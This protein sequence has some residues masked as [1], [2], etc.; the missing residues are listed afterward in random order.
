M[1]AFGSLPLG[2]STSSSPVILNATRESSSNPEDESVDDP[3]DGSVL[4]EIF[5]ILSG[6]SKHQD[7]PPLPESDRIVFTYGK[8]LCRMLDS[9]SNL[10]IEIVS[11]NPHGADLASLIRTYQ[12]I[13]YR[14]KRLI[15]LLIVFIK[16]ANLHETFRIPELCIMVIFFLQ[17]LSPPLLPN[18]HEIVREYQ[19]RISTNSMSK[20]I[21]KGEDLSYLNDLSV[22]PKF[23]VSKNRFSL[24]ELWLKLLRFYVCEFHHSEYLISVVSSEPVRKSARK[25]R[26]QAIF[27]EDPFCPGVSLMNDMNVH[28]DKFF[29]DQLLAAYVYFGIPRLKGSSR[30]FFTEMR[31]ES[32]KFLKKAFSL[33]SDDNQKFA[34]VPVPSAERKSRLDMIASD[35]SKTCSD[36]SLANIALEVLQRAISEICPPKCTLDIKL[37]FG[38]SPCNP[39]PSYAID[40]HLSAFQVTELARACCQNL[41]T[42]AQTDLLEGASKIQL[43]VL[44]RDVLRKTLDTM[45]LISPTMEKKEDVDMPPLPKIAETMNSSN[46]A[47]LANDENNTELGLKGG[48]EMGEDV[49]EQG[50]VIEEM[51]LSDKQENSSNAWEK[52]ISIVD[53]YSYIVFDS[54]KPEFYNSVKVQKLSPD[55][56]AFPFSVDSYLGPI[57]MGSSIIFHTEKPPLACSHCDKRGHISSECPAV[58]LEYWH[59]LESNVPEAKDISHLNEL[60]TCF[61]QLSEYHKLSQE[62][63]ARHQGVVKRLTDLFRLRF[64]DI[65]LELFGSCAN[66]FET[67]NSDVDICVV[68][69]PGSPFLTCLVSGTQK[70]R[71]ELLKTFRKLLFK[72]YND[73]SISNVRPVY[74]AKVPIIK[75]LVD[76]DIEVDL[77]FSNHLAI[78]N[79]KM[80]RL[81]NE[82]EPRLR[83]LN[84]VLKVVLRSCNIPKSCDGG[85][86]SYAYAIM[87][88]H[89]LQRKGYLPCLQ[90]VYESKQRPEFIVNGWNA[91]YQEDK[92]IVKKHWK[93]PTDNINIAELWLGFLRYFLFEFDR[94]AYEVTIDSKE[95]ARR[96]NST[97]SFVIR[98]PFDLSHNMTQFVHDRLIIQIFTTFYDVL[99]HH[100]TFLQNDMNIEE[101]KISLFSSSKLLPNSDSMMQR[102]EKKHKDKAAKPA[103]PSK[104]APVLSTPTA[105]AANVSR[106]VLNGPVRTPVLNHIRGG[107]FYDRLSIGVDRFGNRIVTLP[108]TNRPTPTAFHTQPP[109]SAPQN[110]INSD[111]VGAAPRGRGGRGRGGV[112][113]GEIHSGRGILSHHARTRRNGG[114]IPTFTRSGYGA[115]TSHIPSSRT[116]LS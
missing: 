45:T 86:S 20:V 54:E 24:A 91:W 30:P 12:A 66:G 113:N 84:T 97:N 35:I 70:E 114:R 8:V 77:S 109:Y 100:S 23:F 41:W 7:Q 69:P 111:L 33:G 55:D 40:V 51:V 44:A 36:R 85:I 99:R 72:R 105:A 115:R 75:F 107:G 90:E 98:D 38:K 87:L 71:L 17:R 116:G 18:L 63:S 83:V 76:N 101:W 96:N 16:M 104:S 67:K 80:L 21:V 46:P 28:V 25:I 3:S 102:K 47:V 10:Q 9:K 22:L 95:L 50:N 58:N 26:S 93:V 43:L 112:R 14:A 4:S 53:P 13:D 52:C 61:V 106:T 56:L 2:L 32:T 11:K 94:N 37:S 92:E 19:A 74:H 39:L 15:E 27:V 89:Y 73:I 57:S 1:I 88:I 59:N 65:S 81:Y 62:E 78:Y 29:H 108:T 34:L 110:R 68:F 60:S 42:A 48:S 79:T 5:D 82:Y 6:F 64:P 49:S 31:T 103:P